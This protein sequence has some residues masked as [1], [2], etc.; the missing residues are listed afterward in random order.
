[1]RT[2]PL[3]SKRGMA[4]V[5]V[6]SML[7]LLTVV[8]M[9]FFVHATSNR[10]VE[11]SRSNQTSVS[12][13][14]KSAGDYVVGKFMEE[15][16]LQGNNSSSTNG[17]YFPKAASNAVPKR[18]V[19]PS[20]AADDNFKVLVR[21]SVAGADANASDDSTATA[22]KSG[23]DVNLSR[24]NLPQLLPGSGFT[25]NAQLP[26]WIYVTESGPSN[27]S[28]KQTNGR[29]AYNVYEVGGLLNANASGYP[30]SLPPGP[31]KG[32]PAGADLSQVGASTIATDALIAFRNQNDANYS[33]I[34]SAS[35]RS[36]FLALTPTN[37]TGSV[38]S[39]NRYFSSR[40]DLLRYAQDQNGALASALPYL[41][42]FSRSITAP[43][44]N[45][46]ANGSAVGS[47][48]VGL[49][50]VRIPAGTTTIPHYADNGSL[51][52]PRTVVPGMPLLQTRFS[53][54]K[55]AWIT[56]NGLATGISIEAMQ[57]CFGLRWD[58]TNFRWSYVGN[59]GSTAQ[60]TIKTLATVALEGREPNFFELLKA[61]ILDG[62]LG[63]GAGN[64]TAGAV[65]SYYNGKKDGQVIQIGVNIIDQSH[66]DSYPTAIYFPAVAT[67]PGSSMPATIFNTYFGIKNL[68]YLSRLYSI[69]LN[70]GKMG[71]WVQPQFWNPHQAPSAAV[72][73]GVPTKFRVKTYGTNN[74]RWKQKIA[75]NGDKVEY[76]SAA[77]NYSTTEAAKGILYF[78]TTITDFRDYPQA[79]KRSMLIASDISQTDPKNL[80]QT[81]YP[82]GGNQFSAIFSGETTEVPKQY[83]NN[84]ANREINGYPID[85]YNTVT[86]NEIT[87]TLEYWDGLRW[88]PY[89][90]MACIRKSDASQYTNIYGWDVGSSFLARVDPRT[91]RFSVS[92]KYISNPATQYDSTFQPDVST[93]WPIYKFMPDA[94]RFTPTSLPTNPTD[95]YIGDWVK[96]LP[97]SSA[98]YTDP[99]GV[100]RPG[101]GFRASGD[102]GNPLFHGSTTSSR[103]PVVLNRPFRSVGELGYAFRDLPFKSLDFTSD[104][105]ADA[106]LLDVFSLEDEPPMVAGNININ[107]A[108]QRVLAALLAGG[109]KDAVNAGLIIGGDDDARTVASAIVS[110]IGSTGPILNRSDLANQLGT[111]INN[112]LAALADK[113]NKNQSEAPVR[114]LG[115]IVNLRTWNFLIDVVAQ[116][117]SFPLMDTALSGS[118]FL[119]KGERRYW[120]HVAIDRYT[121]KIVDQQLELVS[122]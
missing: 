80:W 3:N 53:L 39:T 94:A 36:G 40:Q 116:T 32:Y 27:A 110:S 29:F 77:Q 98:R 10:V 50:T 34:V 64:G 35:A 1:M 102:E 21:Q 63:L 72:S 65:D 61:V 30:S 16:T 9:A 13:L 42:H 62:S 22:A 107:T 11:S 112:A 6:L 89:N 20:I 37:S 41:T 12:L 7:I 2:S 59:T 113:A 73:S 101:D 68:P 118:S 15:I 100:L 52:A 115:S 58:S 105:S 92:L 67:P 33:D 14:G 45:V 93:R 119:V 97:S 83:A 31:L 91:D 44:W 48:N 76:I 4:L 87:V 84:N 8:V 75:D 47:T 54:A 43:S 111:P 28:S 26:H 78:G 120:L 81:G 79:L 71:G 106:G 69:T 122:Q 60:S 56:H 38:I 74:M 99:D 57:S 95:T 19:V 25:D 46:G 5:V 96:N 70:T 24:W 23:R 109:T 121:G 90:A 66:A 117:G 17:I 85:S 114:A 88:L 49:L 82:F 55:L 86:P 103:R 108:P 104:K 18:S 51:Q